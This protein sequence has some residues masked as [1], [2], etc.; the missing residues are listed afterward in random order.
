MPGL[1][2]LEALVME[3]GFPDERSLLSFCLSAGVFHD[4]KAKTS[5]IPFGLR[6]EDLHS[7]KV[8]SLILND[9]SVEEMDIKTMNRL[10]EQHLFGG[11]E[12]VMD[13]IKRRSGLDALISLTKLMPP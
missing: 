8:C 6:I 11:I 4:R 5:E 1:E 12:I 9:A 13:R 2:R 10:L 7:Y 3:G